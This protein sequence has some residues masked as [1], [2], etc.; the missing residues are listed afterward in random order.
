MNSIVFVA[1]NVVW[2]MKDTSVIVAEFK[3]TSHRGGKSDGEESNGRLQL[4]LY[5]KCFKIK[6]AYLVVHRT[7]ENTFEIVT[8][9]DEDGPGVSK[10]DNVLERYYEVIE[11][12]HAH[13]KLSI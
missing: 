3:A 10:A 12:M 13:Y 4:R 9:V 7:L 5:M 2:E 1:L 8:L 6:E 11:R